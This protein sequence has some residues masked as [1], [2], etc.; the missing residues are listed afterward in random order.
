MSELVADC[1]R[2]RA[3]QITFDLVI[4]IPIYEKYKWQQWFEAF[5]LCRHC[6]R[7]TVFVLAQKEIS[8]AELLKKGLAILERGVNSVV[9]VESCICIRDF[10]GVAPPEHLPEKIEAVFKEGATCFSAGCY[11]AAASMFRL[12]LDLATKSF[13]P[14]NDVDAYSGQSGH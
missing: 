5:C 9:S 4:A 6:C 13:L 10:V 1:P 3:K 2:C 11:N 8:D 7:T 14:G 12:C